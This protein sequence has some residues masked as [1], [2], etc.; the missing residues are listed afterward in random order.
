MNHVFTTC[1]RMTKLGRIRLSAIQ[2]FGGSG[3]KPEKLASQEYGRAIPIAA[4]MRV[5]VMSAVLAGL[6]KN[7]TFAVRIIWMIKVWVSRDSTNQPVWNNAGLVH[8]L[9]T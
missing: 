1:V 9:K 8:A 3:T 4:M 6:C 7:G 2:Q 5:V